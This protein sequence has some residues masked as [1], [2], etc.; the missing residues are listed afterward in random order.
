MIVGLQPTAWPSGP[1]VTFISQ[2]PAVGLEPTSSALRGWCPACRATPAFFEQPV[3]VS[4]Q[5]DRG[6][7]PPSPAEGLANNRSCRSR[8]CQPGFVDPALE[9]ARQ[10]KQYPM[11]ESNW[12]A[13]LR[14]ASAW[15]RKTGYRPPAGC[16]GGFEPAASTFTGAHARLLH[17]KH[18]RYEPVTREGLE[19]SRLGGHGLLT[20]ACLPFHHLAIYEQWTVEGVEPSFAGCKP[21]VFPLDDTPINQPVAPQGV[22]P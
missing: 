6:S 3:L 12:P 1:G 8:T 9:A 7:K 11:P 13:G 15:S 19:P 4:S 14:R 21:T 20:T 17:H 5:L 18:H 10:P 22:E 2:E 16:S